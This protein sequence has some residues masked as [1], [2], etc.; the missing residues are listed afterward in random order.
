M[1][2]PE[3][4]MRQTEASRLHDGLRRSIAELFERIEDA[5][6]V[7]RSGYRLVACPRVPVPGF[8]GILVDGLDGSAAE[9]ELEGAIYEV[10]GLGVPCWIE[11]RANRTPAIERLARRLG[12]THGESIPGMVVRPD[13]LVAVSGPNLEISQVRDEDG[14]SVAATTAAAGF[15]VPIEP[16]AA[17]FT[18]SVAEMPAVSIYVA[19]ADRRPVSTATAWSGAGGVGIFNVATP[20]EYRGRGYGRA[21]TAKAITD[22]FSAGADLA[23]LQSSLLGERVYRAMG[24]RQV[25]TYSFLGRQPTT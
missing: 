3:A 15:E 8:N 2:K 10:E 17:L 11:V 1:T 13:E 25:E 5:R 12:F 4:A 18:L 9:R 6:L 14:L 16:M 24:F 21:I 7:D 22:G 23:W 19:H 20:P